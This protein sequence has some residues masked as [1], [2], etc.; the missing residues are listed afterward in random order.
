MIKL[1]LTVGKVQKRVAFEGV[2]RKVERVEE[3]G[4]ACEKMSGVY[5]KR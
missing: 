3:I 1:G 2:K 5:R 4:R